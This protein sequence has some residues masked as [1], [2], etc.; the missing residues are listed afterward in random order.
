MQRAMQCTTR[1]SCKFSSVLPCLI[2]RHPTTC[3]FCWLKSWKSHFNS[4]NYSLKSLPRRRSLLSILMKTD[5]LPFLH[6]CIVVNV[7]IV[8]PHVYYVLYC[9]VLSYCLVFVLFCFLFVCLFV[10]F[11]FCF[12]R[13]AVEV[14]FGVGSWVWLGL[15]LVICGFLGFSCLGS[16][17]LK[18]SSL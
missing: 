1:W 12:L 2:C 9:P 6:V 4:A 8:S 10:C 3:P 15:G 18:K 7:Y 17:F 16:V 13:V 14:C 5:F 11:C